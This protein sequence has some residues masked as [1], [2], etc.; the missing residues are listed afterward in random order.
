LKLILLMILSFSAHALT[1]DEAL[2]S[3][4]KHESIEAILRKSKA[5]SEE[6]DLRGSWGDPKFKIAAKNYPTDSLRRDQTPM[7]GIEFGIS[8][9]ISLTTK[10]GNI[11]DA[12]E[13]IAKSYEYEA[14]D[15]KQ[16]LTKGL[17]DVLIISRKIEEE[18]KIL[19]E[20][21]A[22]ISKILKVSKKLYANGKTSQQAILDIQ[23]RK[24]EIESQISNK[25]YEQSQ[26]GDKLNYLVGRSL[27][28]PTSIPWSVVNHKSGTKESS[29]TDFRELS[30]KEKINAK[31]LALTA[32]KQNYIPDMT[33]S[34]GITKRSNIDGNGDFVGASVTF[35][36]PFSGE[37]YSKHGQAVQQK[38]M[39]VKKY[40]N[41][42]RSKLRDVSILKK[43]INKLNDE[44]NILNTKT[45][46][47]AAN[48]RKIT[49]KSYG[50][51]NSSYVELLQSELKLQKILMNKIMLV[52]VRDM[53]IIGL[54]YVLGERLN[55]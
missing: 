45:I 8:Q 32:T 4:Q 42:K 22:W 2:V 33:V 48:S 13:S 23:I 16:G 26:L 6:A 31:E 49:S 41:Y 34:L 44:I 54:K 18:L 38:Y 50:L 35:P 27:V 19:N 37:K 30:L 9:K 55:E 40:E 11:E 29:V 43:E 20:N 21:L 7:T 1:F 10:Y 15:R 5:T 51:G 52:A 47:F 3:L 39:A 36:L 17:W 53:K 14:K 24:S 25:K 46:E 12:F 28:D